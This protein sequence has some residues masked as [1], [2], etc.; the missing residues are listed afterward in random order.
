LT[1]TTRA[2]IYLFISQVIYAITFVVAKILLRDHIGPF[3]LVLLRG[4]GAAPLFWLTDALFIKEKTD[5]KDLPRL[6]LLCLFGV[7]INQTLFIKG[8]SLTSPISAAIM[9][10]TTPI[11]VLIVGAILIRE[12]ISWMRTFG[13]VMGFG[14]AAMLMLNSG[15]S[16]SGGKEDSPFGDLLIFINALSW[17]TYLVLV[18]P[19]MG[20]YHTVTIL[21]WTFTLSM[22]FII[23]I[24]YPQLREVQ[25]ENFT[26]YLYGLLFFVIFFTTFLAYL[27]NVYALKEL[28]PSVVSA[29]IYLQPVLT[30]IIAVGT[31]NDS[32]TLMKVISALFIFAGVY[33]V[34]RKIEVSDDSIE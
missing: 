17:G 15:I 24:G 32:I 5:R 1:Q 9:M 12:K 34:S 16:A 27:L 20:K 6:F 2:H 7:T 31:G 21:R 33:F 23:P 4:L 29:Y 10:I 28:S 8:L 18:K 3:A 26:P 22:I 11:L 19:M 30:A 25:W 14:G 13:I